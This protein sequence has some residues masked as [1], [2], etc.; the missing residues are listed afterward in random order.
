MTE[1]IVQE[2]KANPRLSYPEIAYNVG[3]HRRV[4]S[5]VALKYRLKR[6]S[7]ISS[8]EPVARPGTL[9]ERIVRELKARPYCGY[10]KI[11]RILRT[12]RKRVAVAAGIYGLQRGGQYMRDEDRETMAKLIAETELPYSEIGRRAGGYSRQMVRHF[13]IEHGIQRSHITA[14]LYSVRFRDNFR[15]PLKQPFDFS[16][17]NG[18]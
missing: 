6:G 1:R 5:A 2:L 8:S 3:S 4:V 17:N 13:A 16:I 14:T 7:K 10:M 18:A 12:D 11:A 15:R 9:N